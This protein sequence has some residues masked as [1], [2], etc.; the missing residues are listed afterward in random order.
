MAEIRSIRQSKT[1]QE[2]TG[3]TS[4]K[5][6]FNSVFGY[7]LEVTNSHKSKVPTDWIRKQTLV[8]AERYITPELKEYEE[9]ILGA[10]EKILSLEIKLFE[11]LVEGL[12]ETIEGIVGKEMVARTF[13]LLATIFI[14]ILT[15]NYFGL[16]PG[17]GTVGF[18]EKVGPLALREVSFPLLRPPDAE[19]AADNTS[20]ATAELHRPPP[21]HASTPSESAGSKES[22]S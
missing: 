19:P 21:S 10:E 6:S 12:Y 3:I 14:Y 16:L 13:P 2:R 15:A 1:E 8:N 5:I 18:G 17:V 9:K 11:A 4:L 7:Y 20:S 22:P